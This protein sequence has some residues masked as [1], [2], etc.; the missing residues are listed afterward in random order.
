MIFMKLNMLQDNCYHWTKI[1]IKM[2]RHRP[3][4]HG[5]KSFWM[6]LVHFRKPHSLRTC[7]LIHMLLLQ[8]QLKYTMDVIFLHFD[9]FCS[10][11]EET[12]SKIRFP[13]IFS[14]LQKYIL[15]CYLLNY[16]YDFDQS[17]PTYRK[18]CNHLKIEI[19]NGGHQSKFTLL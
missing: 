15:L 4:F 3:R 11:I 8:K 6:F 5:I 1:E 13:A 18:H 9:T 14:N 19:K 7:V 17:T 2:G 10:L 12:T 16:A